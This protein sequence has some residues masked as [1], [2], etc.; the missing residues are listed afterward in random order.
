[1]TKLAY[2]TEVM[3]LRGET[4]DLRRYEGDVLLI[5][6]TASRCGLTPQFKGLQQLHAEYAEQGLSVLGFPCNQFGGQEPG[7]SDDIAEFC[8]ANYGVDFPMHS[9][10]DVN[11]GGAHPLFD[12]LKSSAKGALGSKSIKW[13]FTKFLV[14]RDGEILRRY[15]PKTP[16][17]QIQADIE[18]ELAKASG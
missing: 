4:E 3:T 2:E 8:Q 13:N 11:G 18:V 14:S 12:Q 15:A 5:V 7:S 10:I 16:P 17:R 1:M 6:N 9:K